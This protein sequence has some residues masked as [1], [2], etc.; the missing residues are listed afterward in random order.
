VIILFI[1]TPFFCIATTGD[2]ARAS[3]SAYPLP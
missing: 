2:E 3:G 1:V